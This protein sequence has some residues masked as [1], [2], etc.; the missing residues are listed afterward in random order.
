MHLN[1]KSS[2]LTLA[3]LLAPVSASAVETSQKATNT[4]GKPMSVEEKVPVTNKDL[5]DTAMAS[6]NHTTLVKLVRDAGLVDMLKGPGPFTVFAPTDA[7]FKKFPKKELDAIAK[8]KAKLKSLL[9]YHVVPSALPLAELI[10][11]T[12]ATTAQGASFDV[13]VEGPKVWVGKAL[14]TKADQIATN[15]VIHSID[16]VLTPPMN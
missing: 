5:V 15:G 8:D 11:T 4:S 1:S 10:K 16:Q 14:V 3:L 6:K 13:K 7:A 9:S 2:F 12:S